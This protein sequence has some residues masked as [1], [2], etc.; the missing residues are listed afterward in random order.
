MKKLIALAV[1][2]LSC[3]GVATADTT[4]TAGKPTPGSPEHKALIQKNLLALAGVCGCPFVVDVNWE[5]V[6]GEETKRQIADSIDNFVGAANSY[7]AKTES[8]QKFC[9]DFRS[10]AVAEDPTGA[11]VDLT[12][13][14]I[15][16]RPHVKPVIVQSD[17]LAVFNKG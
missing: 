17:F 4:V 6:K 2:L 1:V 9:H 15:V 10:L 13:T 5:A 16:I 11:A 3:V 12:D 14:K 7:C 8:K